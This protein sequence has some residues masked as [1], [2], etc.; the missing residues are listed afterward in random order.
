MGMQVYTSSAVRHAYAKLTIGK[1]W[2]LFP[3][4]EF[5]LTKTGT[6]DHSTPNLAHKKVE[7]HWVDVTMLARSSC[8]SKK[9]GEGWIKR[10]QGG[11]KVNS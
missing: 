1:N 7:H 2:S 11:D 3:F 4:S 6:W 8:E 9:D 10:N 5:P